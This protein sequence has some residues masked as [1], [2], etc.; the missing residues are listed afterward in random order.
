MCKHQDLF[1]QG[2]C[3]R[4]IL[5]LQQVLGGGVEED[6]LGQ[7]EEADTNGANSGDQVDHVLALILVIG[8]QQHKLVNYIFLIDPSNMRKISLILTCFQDPLGTPISSMLGLVQLATA[9]PLLGTIIRRELER[10]ARA[11]IVMLRTNSSEMSGGHRNW[12]HSIT[13]QN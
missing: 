4:V 10:R 6:L 3:C 11:T 8:L 7:G 5:V 13:E 9:L 2:S 1:P 12:E